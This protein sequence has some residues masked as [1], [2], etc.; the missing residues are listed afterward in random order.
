VVVVEVLVDVVVLVVVVVL[1]DVVVLV[2]VGATVVVVV[3]V[4]VGAAVV[5]VRAGAEVGAASAT[6]SL[7]PPQA[8][9]P[10]SATNAATV[11]TLRGTPR[12]AI[13]SIMS[14][15]DRVRESIP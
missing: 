8:D 7:D 11:R 5:V 4:V 14:G 10:M 2:V 3:V 12:P 9:I 1:V 15:I 13:N 6:E